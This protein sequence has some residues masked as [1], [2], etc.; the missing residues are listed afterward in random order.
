MRMTPLL[1]VAWTLLECGCGGAAATSVGQDGGSTPTV[2]TASGLA[3][4]CSTND[5]CVSVYFG[6]V[7]GLL[8][9]VPNAAIAS[10]AETTYQNAFNA[11]ASHCPPVDF[12]GSCANVQTITTCASGT[13][14]L[15]TCPG[16]AVSDH[17]CNA[18][19][20]DAGYGPCAIS[21]SNYDQSCAVDSDCTLVT[22]GD[23]CGVDCLCSTA[24][25][26]VSALAAFNAVVATTPVGLRV[27]YPGDCP[28]PAVIGPCCR[29]GQCTTSC[30]SVADTL[31][32]C[33]MA[34]GG[35]C[36]FGSG[37]CVQGPPNSC[38]YADETCCIPAPMPQ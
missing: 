38:A 4:S 6:D 25:I 24:S 10:S 18:R 11:A 34:G 23:Y 21:P 30:Q 31:P 17:A 33:A 13:C 32:A 26:N 15:T 3:T 37:S 14:T 9:C 7:C 8:S 35:Q 20:S 19:V 1:V 22:T 12:G 16:L 5:D 28:C 29:Q 36:L 2:V 27:A